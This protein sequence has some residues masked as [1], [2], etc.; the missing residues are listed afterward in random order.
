MHR[1]Q[2]QPRNAS[3]WTRPTATIAADEMRIYNFPPLEFNMRYPHWVNYVRSLLESKY[4]AQTIYR[5]GF[6]VYTT[7]DPQLQDEAQRICQE[8]VATLVDKNAH[9][10]ALVAMKPSTGEILAMVGSADFNNEE[11]A[12]QIN[13]SISQTRQPGS[14]IKPVTYVAAF[15]KGWTPA[16]FIW[17]VP[18]EFPPSG[19]DHRHARS[20]HSFQLR[21]EVSWPGHCP[22]GAGKFL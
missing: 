18:S 2:Q 21:W 14:S 15:E 9:N 5:S 6:T 7:L 11:I 20:V 17:D 16:T 4:D 8:Q 12:G 3:A 1:G 10:G 19:L 13:M 22:R